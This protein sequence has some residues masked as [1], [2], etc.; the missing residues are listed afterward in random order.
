MAIPPF[1]V[2]VK[3]F[4]LETKGFTEGNQIDGLGLLTY[5]LIWGC[6]NI[7]TQYVS[8][9]TLIATS[10]TLAYGY[11]ISTTWTLCA[12]ASIVTSWSLYTTQGI[13]NC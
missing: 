1:D 9:N 3:G 7:W 10:W 8:S 11:S 5:G 13:E 12:G 2:T 6:D 4:A